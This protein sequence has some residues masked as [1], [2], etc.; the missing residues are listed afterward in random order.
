MNKSNIPTPEELQSVLWY[1]SKTGKLYWRKRSPGMFD[2][3]QLNAEKSCRGWN[4]K[5]SGKE[6]FKVYNPDGYKRGKVFN[7][8]F[9]SHRVCWAIYF[10]QWPEQQIDHINGIRDDNRIENLRDVSQ[11]VNVKNSRKR[12]NNTSGHTG[13]SWLKNNKKWA[14]TI[15]IN[16]RRKYVG[17]FHKKEEAI[18]ARKKAAEKYSYTSRHGL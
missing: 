17:F 9:S 4:K 18:A 3:S 15:N 6:A 5:Y 10:N 7:M 2:N 11:A 13:V 14:A 16:G 12:K 8:T 1:S